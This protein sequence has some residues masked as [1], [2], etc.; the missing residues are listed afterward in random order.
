MR[1]VMMLAVLGAG[2]A[3]FGSQN[4]AKASHCSP[5]GYGGA[6]GGYYGGYAPAYGFGSYY[7][8][9]PYY[10]GYYTPGY[11]GGYYRPGISFSIGV[12]RGYR[13]FGAY[14]IG[15]RSFYRGRRRHHHH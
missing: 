4:T 12:S 8:S 5:Y 14:G 10:G 6:Y 9:Y 15:R 1:K 7:S 13:G 3:L 11:Y 2:L